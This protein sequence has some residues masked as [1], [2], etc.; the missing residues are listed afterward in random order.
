MKGLLYLHF[1]FLI[2]FTS[3]QTQPS[4]CYNFYLGTPGTPPAK[5]SQVPKLLAARNLLTSRAGSG[6][7]IVD[8]TSSTNTEMSQHEDYLESEQRGTLK[9][10]ESV[11]EIQDDLSSRKLRKRFQTQKKINFLASGNGAC[12]AY[13][14]EKQLGI[15]LWSGDA[16][17]KDP[18]KSGWIS[19]DQRGNCGKTVFVQRANNPDTLIFA[20][21]VDGCSFNIADHHT[22]CAQIFLTKK[23]FDAMKP[24]PEELQQGAITNLVWDFNTKA[25][26]VV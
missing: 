17:S 21:V 1:V 7:D 25:N 26:M 20:K 3:A 6:G 10:V 22:G 19:L 14:T 16:K 12:G 2:H 4:G 8:Q 11:S 13:D 5:T 23:A 18:A 9:Y 15:C 24:T